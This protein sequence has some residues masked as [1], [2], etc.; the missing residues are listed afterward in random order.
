MTSR[1]PRH[2]TEWLD[3]HLYRFDLP[4][5]FLG[6]EPNARRKDWDTATVRW[7]MCASWPYEAAAGNSSI[8]A[9]YAAVNDGR[10]EYLCDRFY[11]PNTPGDLKLLERH[12]IPVFGIESRR[13]MAD[14]DVIGSSIS[15]AI[16]S[17]SYIKM[18]TM[19]GIPLRWRD[20]DGSHPMVIVGGVLQ[21]NPLYVPPDEFLAQLAQ[22]PGARHLTGELHGQ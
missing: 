7:L 6:T 3:T 18:L 11:L 20:R 15:Y 13:Q 16:L 19:S 4:Q 12:H 10:P 14:F 1:S 8:P 5:Q 22:R 21:E 9:V 17:M 2:I